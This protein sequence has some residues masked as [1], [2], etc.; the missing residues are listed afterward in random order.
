MR[1]GEVN[2]V[3]QAA[4]ERLTTT[5]AW[6]ATN[7]VYK[8]PNPWHHS[9][10][11]E[12]ELHGLPDALFMVHTLRRQTYLFTRVGNHVVFLLLTFLVKLKC[13]TCVVH[14]TKVLY[15]A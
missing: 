4:Q 7:W 11:E 3:K 8:T 1:V 15:V 5:L 14:M 6:F 2:I 9:T 10:N 13:T 12:V